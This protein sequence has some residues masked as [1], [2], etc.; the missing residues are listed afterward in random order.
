M[1]GAPPPLSPQV[2]PDGKFYWDGRQWV[3]L[4]GA[5][6]PAAMQ[7]PVSRDWTVLV[8]VVIL[9]VLVGGAG[10]I[11][12][13]ATH[14]TCTVGYAGTDLQV[15]AEGLHPH[16][17]CQGFKTSNS[18]GYDVAQPDTTGTLMCRYTLSD[19]TTVAVRDKGILKL[20]GTAECQQL[21]QQ[22][23]DQSLPTPST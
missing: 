6:Q 19:G 18:Q 2:S 17:F 13:Y 20:Y 1:S 12:W 14:Q 22:A 10:G 11:A 5:P 7:P 3:P 21:A 8:V 4:Q 9:V 16:D 23:G 15:T